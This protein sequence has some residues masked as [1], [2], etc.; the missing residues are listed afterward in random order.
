[1][2]AAEVVRWVNDDLEYRRPNW[3]L[4]AAAAPCPLEGVDREWVLVT[5][6]YAEPDTTPGGEGK[7]TQNRFT[8][9]DPS[10]VDGLDALRVWLFGRVILWSVVHEEREYL[11]ERSGGAAYHPHRLDGRA[12]WADVR[13]DVLAKIE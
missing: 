5:L 6:V 13:E 1:M 3:T 11:R 4:S 10:T 9:L 7:F 12:R 2:E 8:L